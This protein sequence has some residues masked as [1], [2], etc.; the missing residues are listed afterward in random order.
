M[1][2]NPMQA[3]REAWSVPLLDLVPTQATV[4][5]R[6]VDLKLGRWREKR[7]DEA[8]SYLTRHRVPVVLGSGARYYLIDRHHLVRALHEEG[9]RE[10]PFFVHANMAALAPEAF[11][12]ALEDRNW[13]HPFDEAGCRCPQEAMPETVVGMTDD[14]FR[15]LAG[16][17]KRAGGYAK[18]QTP[19]SEFRWADFLRSRVPRSLVA[20]DFDLAVSRAL[21]WA[22]GAEAVALPGW[23]GRA[24]ATAVR[25]QSPLS[26]PRATAISGSEAR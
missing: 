3:N 2:G 17:L 4:G 21:E 10:V 16:A 9:V 25:S 22:G 23:R 13:A 6:E 24:D 11:W 19:F 14:V 15:S 26:G 20:S 12:H 7:T 18:D 8:A 5:M 1:L